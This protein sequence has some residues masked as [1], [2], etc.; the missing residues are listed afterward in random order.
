MLPIC[1]AQSLQVQPLVTGVIQSG[2]ALRQYDI[3]DKYPISR[4]EYTRT[5]KALLRI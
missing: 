2:V 3:R 5:M 4:E 1:G